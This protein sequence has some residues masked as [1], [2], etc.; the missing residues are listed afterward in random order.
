MGG[1]M[2]FSKTKWRTVRVVVEVPVRGDYSEKDLVWD[3]KRALDGHL[4]R[5]VIHQDVQ[6]GLVQVKQMN[7]V[8]A[9][10]MRQRV[11]VRVSNVEEEIAK[12][13]V[14]RKA[15]RKVGLGGSAEDGFGPADE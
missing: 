8:L 13:A 9:H 14:V 12:I 11:E 5:R 10:A 6:T 15:M 4:D 2:S 1:L 3:V 7:M